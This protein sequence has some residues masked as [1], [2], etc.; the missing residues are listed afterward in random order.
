MFT[1]FGFPRNF[2]FISQKTTNN[3][4]SIVTSHTDQHETNFT[5]VS[6]GF[7]FVIVLGN[8]TVS[9][10]LSILVNLN[11]GMVVSWLNELIGLELRC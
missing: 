8:F 1:F 5:R 11:E 4:G 10:I 9:N 2:M 6:F 7:K 3:G